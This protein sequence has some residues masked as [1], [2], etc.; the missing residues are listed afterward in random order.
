MDPKYSN[1]TFHTPSRGAYGWRPGYQDMSVLTGYAQLKYKPGRQ[2]C[3]VNAITRTRRPLKLTYYFDGVSQSSNTEDFD[4]LYKCQLKVKIVS[5][6]GESLEL[7]DI[8]LHIEMVTIETAK[9]VL[10]LKCLDGQM[11]TLKKNA[12]T[13]LKPVI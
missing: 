11:K 3:T 2:S 7:D 13:S 8:D 5:Q 4:I 1:N 12:N 9:K 10:L 6:T